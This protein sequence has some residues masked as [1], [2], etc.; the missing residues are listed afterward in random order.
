MLSFSEL[1]F[2][3]KTLFREKKVNNPAF[4]VSNVVSY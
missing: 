4:D 3:N 1:M 2:S